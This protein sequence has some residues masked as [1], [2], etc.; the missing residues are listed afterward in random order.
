L[1]IVFGLEHVSAEIFD[2]AQPVGGGNIA[3]S[4][5]VFLI[6]TWLARLEN[7]L[8]PIVPRALE[9]LTFAIEHNEARGESISFHRQF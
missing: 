2:P 8:T 6:D 7:E 9:W 1:L 3:C 5:L 4:D